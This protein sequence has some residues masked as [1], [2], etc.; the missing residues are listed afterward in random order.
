MTR[1]KPERFEPV[2]RGHIRSH[3]RRDLLV[4]YESIWWNH[5]AKINADWLPDDTVLLT[6]DRRTVCTK[7]GL[8][9]ADVRPDWTPHTAHEPRPRN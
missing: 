6:L 5:S 8:I 9:G 3:G 7:C 2:T 1:R 4:Y